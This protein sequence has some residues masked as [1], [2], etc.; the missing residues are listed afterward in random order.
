M[1]AVDRILRQVRAG[2]GRAVSANELLE[3]RAADSSTEARL[4]EL[5]RRDPTVV[6]ETLQE[7]A[8]MRAGWQ[9]VSYDTALGQLLDAVEQGQRSP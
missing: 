4:N 8:R 7:L 5:C 2:L 3:G 9:H 6:R 1:S